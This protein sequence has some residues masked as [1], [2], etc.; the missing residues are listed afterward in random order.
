MFFEYLLWGRG[1]PKT[2]YTS[3]R[4]VGNVCCAREFTSVRHF[5][6]RVFWVNPSLYQF[7][8]TMSR[9][10]MNQIVYYL[11]SFATM[12]SFRQKSVLNESEPPGVSFLLLF[13]FIFLLFKVDIVENGMEE[14]FFCLCN[15]LSCFPAQS[16]RITPGNNRRAD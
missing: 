9:M 4:K 5:G 12:D 15:T 14:K 3:P 2:E 6:L 10:Q 13:S 7:R 11:P 8:L 16:N 1:V